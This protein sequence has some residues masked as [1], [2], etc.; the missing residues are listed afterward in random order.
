MQNVVN[1]MCEK[2][3][4]DRLRNDRALGNGKSDNNNNKN[5]N[6]R[7]HWGPFWI[8]KLRE[9]CEPFLSIMYYIFDLLRTKNAKLLQIVKLIILQYYT[10]EQTKHNQLNTGS[11]RYFWQQKL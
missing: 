9:L 6:V 7:S 2:F 10:E 1:N 5:N 11:G 4:C 8:Q 3:H